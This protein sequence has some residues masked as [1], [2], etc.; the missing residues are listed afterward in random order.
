VRKNR[1]DLASALGAADGGVDQPD[2]EVSGDL[3][4]VVGGEVRTHA[5]VGGGF[6]R[7]RPSMS[8]TSSSR[9]R[10]WPLSLRVRQ[11]RPARPSRR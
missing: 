7:A 4:E 11:I 9:R 8:V 2:V 6:R 1:S 5:T 3:F 10:R